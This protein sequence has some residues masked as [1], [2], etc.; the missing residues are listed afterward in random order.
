MT[1]AEEMQQATIAAKVEKD[2]QAEEKRR[3]ATPELY[4]SAIISIKESAV[5]GETKLRLSHLDVSRAILGTGADL[6]AV[7]EMLKKDGF[8]ITEHERKELFDAGN[9]VYTISWANP[10]RLQQDCKPSKPE[11]P[12]SQYIYEDGR[13]RDNTIQKGS[14]MNNLRNATLLTGA[15]A[16]A[17]I[18][19]AVV[20]HYFTTQ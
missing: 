6:Q 14:S 9:T 10:I 5:H 19:V 4:K 20:K 13:T 15:I 3:K 17:A 18:V 12:P 8:T 2:K 7:L 1:L 16:I 11:P